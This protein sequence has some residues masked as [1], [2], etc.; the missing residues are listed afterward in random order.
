MHFEK[1]LVSLEPCTVDNR[2]LEIYQQLLEYD[3]PLFLLST[4]HLRNIQ[5]TEVDPATTFSHPAR[6][7]D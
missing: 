6:M 4:T 7:S 2:V 1:Q 5:K 3:K